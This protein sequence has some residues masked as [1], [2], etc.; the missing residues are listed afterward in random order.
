MRLHPLR[1]TLTI[2]DD[3]MQAVR[4][5]ARQQGSSLGAVI[6][7][8]ARRALSTPSAPAAM[9]QQLRNGLPL[10]PVQPQGAPVDLELVNSLRDELP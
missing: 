5:L 3:V 2:D 8:L 4:V 7:A 10:L 1:T 9:G 6:G